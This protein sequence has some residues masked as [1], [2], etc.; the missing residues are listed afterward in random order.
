MSAETIRVGIIGAGA[1]TRRHHI[2]GLTRQQGVVVAAVANRSEA[3]GER[4]A[5]EYGIAHV[6]ADWAE[7]I[8]D[9]S[10]DAV[11]V[12]TWP[13]MH[14]PV[15][16]AA[17]EA[18][19]HVLCEARMAMN[20]LEAHAMLAA[21]RQRPQLTA[22]VV[23]AP[24]TLAFDRTIAD[25][26]GEGFVGHL[27]S[28]DAHITTGSR[29]PDW[30]SPVH[31][32]FD[33]DLSGNNVMSMGIWY[34]AIMR[35]IGPAR[36]V[37]AVTQTVVSHRRAADGRRLAMPV[38]DHVEV[39]CQLVQ[40]GTMRLMVSTVIGHAPATAVTLYGSEGTLRLSEAEG[41]GLRLWAGRRGDPGLRQVELEPSKRGEWR[42]EE[43][44]INAIRGREPVTHTDF[45]TGVKYMEWTDAV[46]RSSRTGETVHL[47]LDLG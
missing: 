5:K 18:G 24:H 21:S 22:Q 10:I 46:V 14:A 26:I 6:A 23:P 2:P 4:V 25:M 36:T 8:D 29:F 13:Y 12:G 9:D 35:W 45:A 1:N 11:C 38:P 3:S 47:P 39:L 37:H 33:R 7:I 43:E 31:W 32:R 27:I 20:S 34:E 41:G 28:V 40:G 15:T 30:N 44:F 19:K 42:V 17:L 16:I